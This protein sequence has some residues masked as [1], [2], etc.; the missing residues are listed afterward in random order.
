MQNSSI[1]Y[2]I[3]SVLEMQFMC[4][5]IFIFIIEFDQSEIVKTDTDKIAESNEIMVALI[6]EHVFSYIAGIF[7]QWEINRYGKVDINGVFR[8]KKESFLSTVEIFIDCIIF[9]FSINHML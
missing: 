5:L 8:A 2:H 6:L 1:I 9:G 3:E 7:R 4:L